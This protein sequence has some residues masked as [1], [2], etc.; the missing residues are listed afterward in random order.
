MPELP[1]VETIK[2][3]IGPRIEG[4]KING[5]DVCNRQIVAYPSADE[6]VEIL[7][8]RIVTK[9]ER[10]GKFLIF[11]MDNGDKMLLHLRMTGQFGR[12]WYIK[13]EE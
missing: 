7:L 11:L 12:F 8:G 6:F 9:M 5:V 10:R 3:I 1:E 2:R 13:K 4:L